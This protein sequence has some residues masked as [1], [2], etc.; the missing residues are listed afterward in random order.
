MIKFKVS[1]TSAN[2]GPGFDCLGIAFDLANT[3]Y[4]EKS[5]KM[6]IEGPKK[7]WTTKD[8]LFNIAFIETMKMLKK[9]GSFHVCY[10][11]TIPLCGGLGTS[12]SVIVAGCK[13]ANL[14]YGGKNKLTDDQIFEIAAKIEGHPDNVAPAIFGGLVA[15]TILNNGKI[16]HKK[17]NVSN[18]L[19]FTIL[20]PDFSISTERARKLLPK[21]YNKKETVKMISHSILMVEALKNGDFELL[22]TVHEDFVHEPYR[23]E[24]IPDYNLIKKEVE[25]NGDAV[26]LISGSGTALLCI[27]KNKDFY[28]NLKLKNAKANWEIKKVKVKK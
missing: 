5:D 25:K 24:L 9:K 26:L 2:V 16:Y 23:K 7:E 19:H 14:L 27:S 20:C 21:N 15:S 12:S 22:K 13:T 4:I 8:N 3:Y 18:K 17:Y 1:A 11:S 10:K 28:K 6:L